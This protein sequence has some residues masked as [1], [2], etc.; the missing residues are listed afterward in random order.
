MSDPSSPGV[1]PL[2]PLSTGELLDAAVA[3]LRVRPGRLMGLGAL[4]ALAEQAALFPL[5]RLADQDLSLLPGTGR[6]LPYG[7]LI[8]A[9]FATEALAIALL[10]AAAARQGPRALLGRVAPPVPRP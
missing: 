2:R 4:R 9:G 6:L 8:V 1:L 10:G 5:R 3:V 7:L